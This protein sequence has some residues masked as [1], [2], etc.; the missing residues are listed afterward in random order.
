MRI[1]A[2][3]NIAASL[4]RELRTAGHDV[5]AVKESMQGATD[6]EVLARAQSEL[7]LVLT[8]DKDFGELAFRFGL[9]VEC[10]IVLLRS[11][12]ADPAAGSRGI[13]NLLGSRSD[14]GQLLLALLY[15]S[16][17]RSERSVGTGLKSAQGN[18]W[19]PT[20]PGRSGPA[21][22]T[23]R[24]DSTVLCKEANRRAA[25]RPEAPLQ[26]R[27]AD[28]GMCSVY[29]RASSTP[30]TASRVP[31]HCRGVRVSRNQSEAVSSAAGRQRFE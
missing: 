3:E 6:T 7:R 2:N 16:W 24:L 20:C 9:P 26:A 13:A 4:I 22:G 30:P 28:W 10:G 15:V 29:R 12:R 8:H 25:R 18:V 27:E 23:S 19:F 1:I 21:G 5:L 14:C 31:A 11:T 17:D